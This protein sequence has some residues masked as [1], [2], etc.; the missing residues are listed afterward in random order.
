M[1]CILYNSAK[2]SLE[3]Q[4]RNLFTLN[5]LPKL[6]KLDEEKINTH[7]NYMNNLYQKMVSIISYDDV[8]LFSRL[9]GTIPL[10]NSDLDVCKEK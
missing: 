1:L 10:L 3:I 6:V 4:F 9:K 2:Y 8:I 7:N 5:F